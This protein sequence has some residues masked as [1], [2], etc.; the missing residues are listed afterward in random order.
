M[1]TGRLDGK[2]A[3][4]TGAARGQGAAEAEYFVAEGASVLLADVLE[5][6]LRAGAERLGDVAVAAFLDVRDPAQWHDAVVTAEREFGAVTVLVN[7]AAIFRA[8]GVV[9]TTPDA[10]MDVVAVNQLG[11]LLGMQAVVPSM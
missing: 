8:G 2:V 11:C 10:Y 7:N 3:I 9:D 6:D 4:V 5:D 1:A